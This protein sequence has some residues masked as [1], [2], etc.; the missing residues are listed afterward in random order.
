MRVFAKSLYTFQSSMYMWEIKENDKRERSPPA[1]QFVISQLGK[2]FLFKVT[3][4]LPVVV[5]KVDFIRIFWSWRPQYK[6]HLYQSP[7][8]VIWQMWRSD[9]SDSQNHWSIVATWQFL[10]C[11][12]IM[13]CSVCTHWRSHLA[14]LY[15]WCRVI[16]LDSFSK[17]LVSWYYS[18]FLHLLFV[19]SHFFG[20]QFEF[21]KWVYCVYQMQLCI[22]WHEKFISVNVYKEH[23]PKIQSKGSCINVIVETLF[24]I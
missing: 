7:Y 14:F 6:I 8:R 17:T 1:T 3:W 23:N 24:K 2:G 12:L 11:I 13:W 18:L 10:F 21:R 20:I 19:L 15:G 22:L 4:D 16:F 5:N 9:H